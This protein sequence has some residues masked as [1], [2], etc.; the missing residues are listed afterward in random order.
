MCEVH[1]YC[2]ENNKNIYTFVSCKLM[3]IVGFCEYT[4]IE[5]TDLLVFKIFGDPKYIEIKLA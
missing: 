5:L 4:D 3:K 1:H 2:W